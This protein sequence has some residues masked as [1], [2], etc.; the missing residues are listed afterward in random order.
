MNDFD[1]TDGND[2]IDQGR[3]QVALFGLVYSTLASW[4]RPRLANVPVLLNVPS[5]PDLNNR[6]K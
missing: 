6:P 5:S 4:S 3:A 1:V 2:G